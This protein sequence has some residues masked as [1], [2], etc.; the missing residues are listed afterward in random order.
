MSLAAVR[1]NLR[2]NSDSSPRN[3]REER[4]TKTA[5]EKLKLVSLNHQYY[6]DAAVITGVAGV[7]CAAVGG[8][9]IAGL[10]CCP[11]LFFV[12]AVFFLTLAYICLKDGIDLK[13]RALDAY[14]AE[15]NGIRFGA[16]G[17]IDTAKRK[18]DHER[19][20]VGTMT[21]SVFHLKESIYNKEIF[22]EGD[23]PYQIP[24]IP[25]RKTEDYKTT[26]VRHFVNRVLPNHDYEDPW[27]RFKDCAKG[28]K[29]REIEEN[30][31]L[32][33]AFLIVLGSENKP[34]G[35][36]PEEILPEGGLGLGKPFQYGQIPSI[37]Y[38]TTQK[39]LT[40]TDE[41]YPLYL[42]EEIDDDKPEMLRTL[43]G[44][45][46]TERTFKIDSQEGDEVTVSFAQTFELSKIE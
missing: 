26:I 35:N 15:D 32:L 27:E 40:V 17:Q 38:S 9:A 25:K 24:G 46:T 44:T 1:E 12:G 16:S 34:V 11:L 2:L 23:F 37:S 13:K 20:R 30:A 22:A 29:G 31:V 3:E 21:F 43:L 6:F 7:A 8:L 5:Q 14:R 45:L 4:I 36:V 18:I 39:S 10:C 19:V 33:A 42:R 41:V 28:N